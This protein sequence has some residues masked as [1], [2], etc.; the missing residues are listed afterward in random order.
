MTVYGAKQLADSFRTV[1]KNT[2][3]I[4][5]EIPE[6]K[7]S[8]RATPDTR[9][10]GELLVHIALGPSFQYRIH[11]EE[12]RS[13]FDGFDFPSMMK[14]LSAEEKK[15]RSKEQTIEMLRTSGDKF[16]N[17]LDGLTDAFLA[18]QFQG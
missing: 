3:T 5:Q 4:A 9:S 12:R 11:A 10:A 6:D 14:H 7:Y 2:I 1:R 8:F 18:E 15:P 16:G 13:S 17:W